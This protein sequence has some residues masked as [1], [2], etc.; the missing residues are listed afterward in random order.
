MAEDARLSVGNYPPGQA[1]RITPEAIKA[2]IA[3][4]EF[5]SRG[6]LTICILTLRNGTRVT[7]ESACV[8]PENYDSE[9][10]TKIAREV[11]ERK[12]YALEGYLLATRRTEDSIRYAGN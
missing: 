9:I 4:C 11:A 2:E 1:P 7:G 12:V 5:I 3:D 10:G 6:T 8:Y